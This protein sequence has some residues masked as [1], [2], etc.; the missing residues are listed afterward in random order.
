MAGEDSALPRLPVHHGVPVHHEVDDA[1]RTILELT[2]EVM[3]AAFALVGEGLIMGT[4]PPYLERFGSSNAH[5]VAKRYVRPVAES[6]AE[7]A[8]APLNFVSRVTGTPFTMV[9]S[10]PHRAVKRL[11]ACEFAPAFARKSPFA[12][13]MVCR[14][15]AA[16]YQGS[17]NALLPP[18][19]AGYRVDVRSRILFGDPHCDFAVE[20]HEARTVPPSPAPPPP[21]PDDTFRRDQSCHFYTAILVAFVEYL[22]T[23][24]PEDRLRLL[25]TDCSARVGKKVARLM[26]AGAGDDPVALVSRVLQNGGRTTEELDDAVR[27]TSCLFAAPIMGVTKDHEDAQRDALRR[28]S[29]GMCHEMMAALA[30]QTGED[31]PME[32]PRCLTLGD[33]DCLFRFRGGEAS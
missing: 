26:G 22:S 18:G 14:L 27:V 31:R 20:S 11:H 15:H 29:C 28:A 32:R 24:L 16:V 5:Y 30:E 8:L 23:I 17:V 19:D 25:L 7:A 4:M 33:D 1:A 6:G 2:A 12:K 3:D 10:S 13:A 21:T 9:E